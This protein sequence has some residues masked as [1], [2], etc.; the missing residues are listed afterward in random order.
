MTPDEFK[1]LLK[2]EQFGEINIIE[3]EIG[4]VLGD[5]QHPYDVCA[6]ITSGEITLVVDGVSTTY[7][8]G[9]IFRLSVG[10]VHHEYAGPMGANIWAGRRHQVAVQ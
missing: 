7:A 9:D 3:R 10:T 2:A 6:L 8:A 1:N 5:H 4:Y